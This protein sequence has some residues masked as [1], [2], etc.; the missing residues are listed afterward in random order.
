MVETLPL[1]AKKE[2][3]VAKEYGINKLSGSRKY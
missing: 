2:R 3:N 1:C